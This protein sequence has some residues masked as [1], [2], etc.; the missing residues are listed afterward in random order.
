MSGLP[1]TGSS[2]VPRNK[3]EKF[4]GSDYKQ[5]MRHRGSRLPGGAGI[6]ALHIRSI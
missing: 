5:S 3:S 1:P 4:I 2:P 6:H